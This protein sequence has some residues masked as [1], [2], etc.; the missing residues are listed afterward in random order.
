MSGAAGEAL[1]RPVVGLMLLV[2]L[3]AVA[4]TCHER[5]LPVGDHLQVVGRSDRDGS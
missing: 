5:G 1:S 2:C 3:A 4:A